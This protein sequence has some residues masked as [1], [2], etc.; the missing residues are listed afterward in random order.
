MQATRRHLVFNERG[1]S[2]QRRTAYQTINA[3]LHLF[4]SKIESKSRADARAA[5]LHG[6]I[7]VHAAH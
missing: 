1:C 6:S 7:E 2:K 4:G 5:I 3:M